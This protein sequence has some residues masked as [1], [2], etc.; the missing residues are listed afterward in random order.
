MID[1]IHRTCEK[2]DISSKCQHLIDKIACNSITEQY[3]DIDLEPIKDGDTII[4]HV[5]CRGEKYYEK[6]LIKKTAVEAINDLKVFL[7][8]IKMHYFAK[9]PKV[10]NTEGQVI[11][12]VDYSENYKNKLK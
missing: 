2:I 9:Q 8:D 3:P 12:H 7:N 10:R 4:F 5:K 11:I 1:G 6:K